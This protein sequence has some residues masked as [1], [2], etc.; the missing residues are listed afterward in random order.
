MEII[1]IIAAGRPQISKPGNTN[2]QGIG[3]A[4]RFKNIPK[5]TA[6][7]ESFLFPNR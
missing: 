5:P 4:R 1:E 7:G 2:F 3:Q 6:L